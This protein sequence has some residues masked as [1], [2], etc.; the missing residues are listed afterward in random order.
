MLSIEELKAISGCTKITPGAA[1]A[2]VP[3]PM[4]QESLPTE[5]WVHALEYASLDEAFAA[6]DVSKAFR[7]ASRFALNKGRWAPVVKVVLAIKSFPWRQYGF[8]K[9]KHVDEVKAEFCAAWHV[10]EPRLL[11]QIMDAV[12]TYSSADMEWVLGELLRFAEPMISD[13]AL[14]RVVANLEHVDAR[15]P[16]DTGPSFIFEKWLK[17]LPGVSQVSCIQR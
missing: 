12:H 17:F 14:G 8:A 3:C 9:Q 5:L 1:R 13:D 6:F 2:G 15:H 11:W 10:R 16:G 4:S 7:S